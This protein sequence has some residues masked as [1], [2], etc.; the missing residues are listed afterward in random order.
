M[1][2]S[3]SP[4]TCEPPAQGTG[5]RLSHFLNTDNLETPNAYH[6]SPSDGSA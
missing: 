6:I 2:A 1:V 5:R 4:T 3:T